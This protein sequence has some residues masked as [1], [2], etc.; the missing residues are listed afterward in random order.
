MSQEG[1]SSSSEPLDPELTIVIP[2][3]NEGENIAEVLGEI[4]EKLGGK[5]SFEVLFVDDGSRDDTVK[6]IHRAKERW[7]WIRLVRHRRTCGK[8]S[9]LV[10]GAR[11]AR[12]AWIASMDGDGQN[13]PADLWKL[14]QRV[15]QPGVAA[16][17][18]LVAGQRRRRNDTAL[19]QMSSRVANGVRMYLSGDPVPDA[20]CGL[21][22]YRRDVFLEL[23]R[24]DNMHRFL[25]ALFQRHG[26]TVI[27]VPIDDR[28]RI[29]GRSKYGFHNRLWVGIADLFGVIWLRR[30]RLAIEEMEE[31]ET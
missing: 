30:R 17:L 31:E 1:A 13:D 6:E 9:A 7:P 8:S 10:T 19:K 25:S 23:P 21:K 5:A 11:R 12:G 16:D 27:S 24:F 29:H 18:L 20:A 28:P 22:V 26:G 15:L 14:Y 3:L 2:V 4:D